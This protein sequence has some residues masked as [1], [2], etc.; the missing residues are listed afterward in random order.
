MQS[1]DRSN[2][3]THKMGRSARIDGRAATGFANATKL[4]LISVDARGAIR[5]AYLAAAEVFGCVGQELVG[6]PG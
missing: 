6:Q 1:G 3:T 2:P 5:F 4:S